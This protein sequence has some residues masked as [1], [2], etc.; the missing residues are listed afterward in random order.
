MPASAVTY[1]GRRVE[2]GRARPFGFGRRVTSA[3][4]GSGRG[5]AGSR[6]ADF[7]RIGSKRVVADWQ[8]ARAPN[9]NLPFPSVRDPPFHPA[10]ARCGPLHGSPVSSTQDLRPASELETNCFQFYAI[11]HLDKTSQDL[12]PASRLARLPPLHGRGPLWAHALGARCLGRTHSFLRPPFTKF[13][14]N[15]RGGTCEPG[16][17]GKWQPSTRAV[18]SEGQL[19]TGRGCFSWVKVFYW[20]GG[21]VARIA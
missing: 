1:Q 9:A 6:A 2:P 17:C 16:K 8:G 20:G 11:A 15:G 18:R 19:L 21:A 12:R 10:A 7:A 5:V 3:S 13:E 14:N 4:R